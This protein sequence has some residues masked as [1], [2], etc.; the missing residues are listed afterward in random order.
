[1]STL[2]VGKSGDVEAGRREIRRLLERRA[3]TQ[4]IGLASCGSVFRNPEGDYAARLIE[5]CG[6]KGTCV[7]GACVSEKHANFIINTGAATALDIEHLIRLVQ[8]RVSTETG[9]WLEPEV[10]IVGVEVGS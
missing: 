10:R 4:P 1:M 5:R 7:G 2:L 9:V 8:Q 3:E 6:L